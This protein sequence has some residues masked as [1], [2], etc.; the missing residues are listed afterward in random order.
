MPGKC[1]QSSGTKTG[2]QTV[3]SM[4]QAFFSGWE[5]PATLVTARSPQTQPPIATVRTRA[6]YSRPT[7]A[8]AQHCRATL[9]GDVDGVAGPRQRT[10]Q[11]FGGEIRDC[12]AVARGARTGC[13]AGQA[14]SMA[15]G[16]IKS[17]LPVGSAWIRAPSLD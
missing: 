13:R 12:A 8:L 14:D 4:D 9:L 6:Q 5:L 2:D 11:T 1:N 16:H 3:D 7:H 17:S 15:I 10:G